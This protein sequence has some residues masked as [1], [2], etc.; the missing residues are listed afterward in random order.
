LQETIDADLLLH[1]V[2]AGSPNRQDHIREVNT[3]LKEIGADNI[4]QLM[5]YNKIDRLPVVD[6]HADKSEDGKIKAVWLS[7]MMN[8]GVDQLL[9]ALS[10]HCHTDTQR[11]QITLKPHQAKLRAALFN[12]A[13]II[14]ETV[15]ENGDCLLDVNISNKYS[16]LL[17][18]VK[19]DG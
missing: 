15:Q 14:S 12:H 13:Q 18:E 7:A 11:Q 9:S 10:A 8:N 1:V 3:V 2:D 4:P 16:Y 19:A 5:V 6:A 17:D